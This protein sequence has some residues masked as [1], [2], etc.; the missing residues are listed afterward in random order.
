MTP[1]VKIVVPRLPP[2]FVRRKPLTDM[3]DRAVKAPVTV[4][5]APAGYGKTLLLADWVDTTGDR[6]KAWLSLDRADNEPS[7]FWSEVLSALCERDT[8]PADSRLRALVPPGDTDVAGFIAEFVDALDALP[9]RLCLVLDD[10]HEVVDKE[11]LHG[12]ETLI[13]HQ[14]DS[15][16][17]VLSSRL[18]PPLPLARLRLQ[19]RLS[20]IRADQLRFADEDA[21][22]LLETVDVSL[23][24]RQLRRLV[25]ETGGWAAGLRLAARSLRQ[26]PDRDAF[27]ADFASD[28]RAIAD[29]L[30]GEVL[31]ALPEGTWDFLVAISVCDEVAPLLAA[32]LSGRDDAGAILDQLERDN[33]LVMGVGRDRHWYRLHPLLRSYLRGDL[34]RRRPEMAVDL[35]RVAATWFASEELPRKALDHAAR[36]DETDTVIRLL[37]RHA[38]ALLLNGDNEVVR[39]ALSIVSAEAVDRDAWLNLISAVTHLEAGEL[40][41]GSESLAQADS[42]PTAV[43]GRDLRAL[44]RLVRSTYALA[45][46]DRRRRE[47]MDWHDVIS[48]RDGPGQEAWARLVS[49]WALVCAGERAEGRQELDAAEHLA[50]GLG[51]DYLAMHGLLARGVVAVLDGDYEAMETSGSEA[52]R[53]AECHGW[54]KSSWVATAYPMLGFARLMRLDPAGALEAAEQATLLLDRESDPRLLYLSKVVESGAR[55]DLGHRAA[56]LR[57]LRLARKALADVTL[58]PELVVTAALIEYRCAVLLE[59]DAAAREVLGWARRRVGETAEST[60]MTAWSQ[61]AQGDLRSAGQ[62]LDRLL[63]ARQRPLLPATHLEGRLLQSALAIRSGQRTKARRA[64]EEAVLLAEPATL[65]RPF[66]QADRRVREL[67]VDQLGSFGG[68]DGFAG[69]IRHTLSGAERDGDPVLTEREQVVLTRLSSQR[70]LGEV[71]T[72]LSVSVNTV[73]THVRA[74]YAKLG[75]NNRRAAVFTARGRGLT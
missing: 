59:D 62:A 22:A 61:F 35:H 36:A 9:G 72:D 28:D 5:S 50:R 71:A 54:Q 15:L 67:L 11:S 23:D 21:A 42:A 60:L 39:R 16:R 7:Q 57:D 8:V 64:L 18:D 69:R 73:K 40:A 33:S 51:L 12:I 55:F 1:H 45:G 52:V 46:G 58:L 4:V 44:Y 19:G 65:I 2:T 63:G 17:L 38:V 47:E 24:E 20:V 75:V 56:G 68:A 70:S 27:L 6:D 32:V 49:G 14:P 34:D 37:H 48:G 10:F 31:A 13:R 25:K 43:V 41:A 74:I 66:G 26:A 30:V 29:Y 3:L 53:I